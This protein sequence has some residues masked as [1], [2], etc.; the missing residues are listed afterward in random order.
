M[1]VQSHEMLDD[2]A[3]GKKDRYIVRLLP[4]APSV[5]P[6][7]SIKGIRA[8]GGLELDLAWQNGKLTSVTLRS[9]VDTDCEL[10]YGDKAI[11]FAAKAGSVTTLD[12][13]L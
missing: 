7:G 4:A 3:T 2:P 5:W 6:N 1:L 13:S 8:R 10:V 12:G 11:N 9:E